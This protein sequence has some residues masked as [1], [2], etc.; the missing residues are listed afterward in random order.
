MSPLLDAW[1]ARVDALAPRV[2]GPADRRG[3]ALAAE[4]RHLSEVYTRRRH[5]LTEAST[6]LAAR[7]RFFFLRDL[8][9]VHGPL[10]ELARADGLP[11]GETWRVL[12]LGAGLGTTTLGLAGFAKMR[13][14]E[15]LEVTALERD[16]ASIDVFTQL[17]REAKELAPPIR[18]DARRADLASIDLGRLPKADLI[19]LGLALNEL[20]ADRDEA[21]RLDAMGAFVRALVGRLREGGS[22]IVLEPA[23]R[24][25]SRALQGLRDRFAAS[26]DITVFAPCLRD[27]LCPL[28]RRE[29]DWCHAAMAVELP[30]A[31]AAIA[32]SAGLRRERLT[33]A[34]LTLRADGRRLWDAADRDPRVHRIVGGPVSSKGKT[35]WDV[36]SASGLARLRRLD[37]ERAESNR[38]LDGAVRG[39]LLRLD[40]DLPDGA[41]LRVRPDVLVESP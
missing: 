18:L 4:V 22:L 25:T 19:L 14:I 21:A 3:E 27:G 36:C 41:Q 26:S 12:D 40:R 5:A 29:R 28:L 2:L 9:K 20:F 8:L 11:A 33:Y 16:A 6:A 35:E 34:H 1:S 32:K 24:V 10:E 31:L 13:G 38:A 39:D 30:P 23:L 7:L 37:R 17:V 15:R